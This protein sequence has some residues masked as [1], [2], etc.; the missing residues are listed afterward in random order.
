MDVLITTMVRVST[1]DI[2]KVAD[3]MH[4]AIN[5]VIDN[6]NFLAEKPLQINAVLSFEAIQ[7]KAS[8]RAT[9]FFRFPDDLDNIKPHI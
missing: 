7:V 1:E 4:N 8:T 9:R 2:N 5:K 3:A 6:A